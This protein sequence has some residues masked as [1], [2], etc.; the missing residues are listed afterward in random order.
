MKKEYD[1][2]LSLGGSCAEANQLKVRGLRMISLP[3]DWLF[4]KEAATLERLAECFCDDFT[5][6]LKLEN[7]VEID[8]DERNPNAAKYQYKDLYT[9]YRFIHDFLRPKEECFDSVRDKYMRRIARCKERLIT[10]KRIAIC[11]DADFCGS[12]EPMKNVRGVLLNL[13]GHD[14]V[15]DGY[16]VEFDASKHEVEKNDDLTVYRFTHPKND[17]IFAGHPSFEFAYMDDFRISDM[18]M[19]E[20]RGKGNR[21]YLAHTAHGMKCIL[22]KNRPG[23]FGVDISF[24]KRKYEFSIGGGVR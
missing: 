21:L 6:W 22:W 11:F 24:G 4:T 10:A 12:V 13:F 5:N 7:L 3:F 16:L 23:W 19:S 17:Y 15:I 14:K 20:E 1:L 8:P 9:G 18:F 2:V